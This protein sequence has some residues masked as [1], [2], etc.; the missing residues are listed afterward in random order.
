MKTILITSLSVLLCSCLPAPEVADTFRDQSV[1]GTSTSAAGIV[2][3]TPGTGI[4][5]EAGVTSTFSIQLA[6]QPKSN[7]SMVLT[8][9]DASEIVLRSAD[10]INCDNS[11]VVDNNNSC[12]VTFT[13]LNYSVAQTFGVAAVDDM[14]DEDDK[15]TVIQIG[16][17]SSNDLSYNGIDPS[18]LNIT[19]QDNDTA[20]GTM[21]CINTASDTSFS[22]AKC[23]GGSATTTEDGSTNAT[24]DFTIVLNTKPTAN[25]TITVTSSDA[26]E[27]RLKESSGTCDTASGTTQTSCTVV[28]N[29]SNWNIPKTVQIRAF[30]DFVLNESPSPTYAINL[31]A[32]STDAKY[33]GITLPAFTGIVSVQKQTRLTFVTTNTY[34][35]NLGG[36]SG[37]DAKCMADPGHPD[38]ALALGSR[39]LFK[40]FIVVESVRQITMLYSTNIIDWPIA[41]DTT[42]FRADGVTPIFTSTASR[43]MD[44]GLSNAI[45]GSSDTAWVAGIAA[46]WNL[47]IVGCGASCPRLQGTCLNFTS[48]LSTTSQRTLKLNSSYIENSASS[49]DLLNPIWCIG[50]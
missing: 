18:D 40:A 29:T 26:T 30:N 34:N 8:S 39:R 14:I 17:T 6:S 50:Q 46:S 7:V 10:G 3:V 38:A 35:G 31:A 48:S 33:Q 2:V 12:I 15:V 47:Y 45:N 43:T 11:A 16:T 37:A 44:N 4:V 28:F 41:S 25:V 20:G 22:S 42:Y 49:C 32:S 24:L 1:T 23:T 13:P 36:V 5:S 27:G 9:S 21:T 19:V